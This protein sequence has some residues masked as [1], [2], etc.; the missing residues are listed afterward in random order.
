MLAPSIDLDLFKAFYEIDV[1]RDCGRYSVET[2]PDIVRAFNLTRYLLY[3]MGHYF[4]DTQYARSD[5]V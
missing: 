5:A 2:Q 1:H 4:L 3:K